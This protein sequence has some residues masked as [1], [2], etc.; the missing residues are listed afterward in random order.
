MRGVFVLREITGHTRRTLVP[1]KGQWMS[2][3]GVLPP[4]AAPHTTRRSTFV[5]VSPSS[6]TA[7]MHVGFVIE[8][9]FSRSCVW[10]ED[11]T[12]I[13]TLNCTSL[14]SVGKASVHVPLHLEECITLEVRVCGWKGSSCSLLRASGE[15]ERSDV[16]G[17]RRIHCAMGT[18]GKLDEI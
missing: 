3:V 17:F 18:H 8:V 14:R 10:W 1:E 7:H 4:G 11:I 16:S 5:T 12:R 2:C 15:S 9:V 13:C 6:H